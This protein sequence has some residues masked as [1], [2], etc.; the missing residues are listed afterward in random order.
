MNEVITE[1][2]QSQATR[3]LS[4]SLDALSATALRIRDERDEMASALKDII[5]ALQLHLDSGM[6]EGAAL[7]LIK[8][9]KR[10]AETGLREESVS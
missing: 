7:A 9:V 1:A 8:A 5:F 3:E 6:W 4:A 10:V 2:M